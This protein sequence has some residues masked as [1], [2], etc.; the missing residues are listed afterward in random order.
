VGT[1][2]PVI[3]GAK[4]V[5]LAIG[6]H[7]AQAPLFHGSTT[8]ATF[9]KEACVTFAPACKR[10][11]SISQHEVPSFGDEA[12]SAEAVVLPLRGQFESCSLVEVPGG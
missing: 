11:S 8:R 12:F 1:L 5:V 6:L 10:K 2:K 9:R 7:G 4:A 3:L